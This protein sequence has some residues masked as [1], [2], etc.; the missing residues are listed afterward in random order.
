M[1]RLNTQDLCLGALFYVLCLCNPK[2]KTAPRCWVSTTCHCEGCGFHSRHVGHWIE[3][4]YPSTPSTPPTWMPSGNRPAP[5]SRFE[6][7]CSQ[8]SQRQ[9][10]IKHPTDKLTNKARALNNRDQRESCRR[11]RCCRRP[12]FD[13][14]CVRRGTLWVCFEDEGQSGNSRDE[15]Y[16][17]DHVLRHRHIMR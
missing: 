5:H 15:R 7:H 11:C 16:D 12:T 13:R 6:K 17:S 14:V 3:L 2:N 8:P 10:C 9:N 4:D 1:C